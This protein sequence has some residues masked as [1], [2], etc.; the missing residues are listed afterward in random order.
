MKAWC[1]NLSS[2]ENRY[3]ETK[4]KLK[5]LDIDTIRFSINAI[6]SPG[7]KN[8]DNWMLNAHLE[9]FNHLKEL[10]DDFFIIVDD[11]ILILKKGDINNI[12]K[13]A[14]VDWDVI[15]LGGMNHFHQPT[16]YDKIFYIPKFSFNA[17]AYIVKKSFLQ[18]LINRVEKRDFVL[19]VIFSH[20]Q[21]DKIGNW[22]G[23][24]DDIIIQSGK[25]LST[26]ITTW[27]D[28]LKKIKE[29][30]NRRII[31]KEISP[32][33]NYSKKEIFED[34]CRKKLKYIENKWPKIDKNSK[35]KSLIVESRFGEHIEFIIKNTIQK[36]GDGWGHIIVCTNNNINEINKLVSDINKDIEIINLGDFHI[37]RNTYNN[38]CLDIEFWKRINCE[39][40]LVYQ[41]DTLIFKDFDNKFLEWD[42]IGAPWGPSDHSQRLKK[43]TV[44]EILVG[45]G[46]LSLRNI[47]LIK[48]ILTKYK[49]N[50]T[51]NSDTDFIYEDVFFS[52]HINRVGKLAPLEIAKQFSF[53]HIFYDN[54]FGCHQPYVD[55]FHQSDL[56]ER[57]LDKIQGVNV[58][59]FGNYL[60][61]LG[62]NMR[63]VVNALDK[64]KIPHNI[65]ELKC[66][67]TRIEFLKN[68][69]FNYFN[70]NL[71]L[72]NP[73]FDLLNAVGDDY[74][75]DKK[76]IAIWA[77]ELGSLP[78]KW[79]ENANKFDEI[80]TISEFCF[81]T[82]KKYLPNKEIKLIKIPGNFR[83]KND[84]NLSKKILGL[85]EKFVVTFIFDGY[86]D[87]IR[88][89]PEAV[90]K[91]FDNSLLNFKDCL[92]IIKSH[93]LNDSE[94]SLL[95]N[96][97][98]SPNKI[99]I[100]ES[101]DDKKMTDL[102][103]STD[104][105]ISLHRSEGSGLTIMES[106]Y[107]GIPTITT[108]WSGNLD[109]CK[110]DF[111][112]LVDYNMVNLSTDSL[113]YRMF[114]DNSNLKWA[115]ADPL[116]ASNKLL[117][118]YNRYDWY[119]EKSSLGK[120][121]IDRNYN[122]EEISNFLKTNL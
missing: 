4:N 115:D 6:F 117:D 72:C 46:G 25:Y 113:Y 95:S 76:N 91:A 103:S 3:I 90:I 118:I 61:G 98:N 78:E 116:N 112:E 2:R 75:K 7:K 67:S 41:S 63:V 48:D 57:F 50:E 21:K 81:Q 93:N 27:G 107:L 26:F 14:P 120:D 13:S 12:I 22:Y 1:I 17:H 66:G 94:V 65:N 44:D 36:L 32:I 53:E 45:N 88:K 9:L 10:D 52:N 86:S 83:E 28:N 58:L 73:D 96:L 110:K 29:L 85:E 33:R 71:I 34:I 51:P 11:D 5:D 101:W 119:L 49:P 109:F 100:N 89:N 30:N 80:W 77:W 92:L 69:D 106:I 122:I 87:R 31:L 40:A 62:H 59:G 121:F 19:D 16:N 37:D 38:L 43:Y 64:A 70:T 99:L 54:T 82:F 55:S 84:K 108:N 104:V 15:Y 60:L 20:M 102:I 79:I 42:Y 105:Y 111:C 68:D 97:C 24:K 74:I 35:L 47:Q 114:I 18:T 8:R 23:V 56:F 39:T